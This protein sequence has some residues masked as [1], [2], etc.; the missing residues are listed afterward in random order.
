MTRNLMMMMLMP[1]RVIILFDIPPPLNW[2]Y[3]DRV[4]VCVFDVDL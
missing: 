4:C 2:P 1:P 3:A